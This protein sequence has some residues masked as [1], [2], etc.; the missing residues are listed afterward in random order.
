MRLGS[1]GESDP[2][3]VMEHVLANGLAGFVL[4]NYRTV[5]VNDITNN[6]LWMPLA[7]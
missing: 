1:G 6:P 5:I 7:R 3:A 4:H 2:H